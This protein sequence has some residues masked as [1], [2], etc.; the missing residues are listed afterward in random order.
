MLMMSPVGRGDNV[1]NW[2]VG[3][4]CDGVGPTRVI[5]DNV[6]THQLSAILILPPTLIPACHRIYDI[7]SG[8]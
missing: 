6:F 2:K 1:V 5:Q 3:A 4:P 8:G 7:G